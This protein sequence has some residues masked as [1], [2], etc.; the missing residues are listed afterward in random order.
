[1]PQKVKFCVE[2]F[3]D[4]TKVI[5]SYINKQVTTVCCSMK[6]LSQISHKRLEQEK[7]TCDHLILGSEYTA[8]FM[9]RPWCFFI[10]KIKHFSNFIND[11]WGFFVSNVL[12]WF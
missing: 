11:G 8:V 5:L 7:V 2:G 10:H 4:S 3:T 6:C 1:M 12:L 9:D